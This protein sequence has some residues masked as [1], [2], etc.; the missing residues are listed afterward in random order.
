MAPHDTNRTVAITRDSSSGG[1]TACRSVLVVM[2]PTTTPAANPA[3]PQAK[4]TMPA[5]PCPTGSSRAEHAPARPV[6]S[7]A[8]ALPHRLVSRGARAAPTSAPMP[9]GGDQH[10]QAGRR[11]EDSDQVD[12]RQRHQRAAGKVDRGGLP[13]ARAHHRMTDHEVPTNADHLPH[14]GRGSRCRHPAFGQ[15]T[16][17]DRRDEVAAGVD[18]HRGHRPD[19]LH[20]DTADGRAAELDGR[21]RPG[22]QAVAG[23]QLLLRHQPR[24][25]RGT[26]SRRRRAPWRSSRPA[27]RRRGGR[28]SAHPAT[29][30]RRRRPRPPAPGPSPAGS[31]AAAVADSAPPPG[32]RSPARRHRRP[33]SAGRPRSRTRAGP[34]RP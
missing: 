12:G 13:H 23:S 19:E 24:Q 32:G 8:R 5:A 21:V 11:P 34:P 2:L 28:R 9:L 30:R 26:C 16:G 18:E 1:V 17:Q 4:A 25:E 20:Q 31:P 7:V 6:S 15:P 33:P 10:H 22:H 27:P 3:F 29:G 14:R